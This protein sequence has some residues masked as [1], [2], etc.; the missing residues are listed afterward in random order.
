MN[1][2]YA[3]Q[4]EP[5]GLSE[6]FI[7]GE[8]FLNNHPSLLVLGD[9][10]FYGANLTSILKKSNFNLNYATI[11]C[12][13]VNDPRRYGVVEFD[14]SFNVKSI[15]EKPK[16]P[17]SNYAITGVYYFDEMAC[18][19][20]KEISISTR[21]ELEITSLIDMY[22][23]KNKL[24][25]EVMGRGNAWFDTGTF[26]SL[27]QASSFIM[28][29][30]NRQGFKVGCPEEISWRNGWISDEQLYILSKPLQNSG[31]GIYLKDL[32]ELT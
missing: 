23:K 20:A 26:E 6:A 9:N 31:Y 3:I 19:M 28:T 25:V 10:I 30:E 5:R 17:K 1:F 29:L 11:F 18:Q 12:H 24:K 2:E 8:K 15:E 13:R 27:H 14:N 22:L 16:K 4:E 21:G 32:L 7:I